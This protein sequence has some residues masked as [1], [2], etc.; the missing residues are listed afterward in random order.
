MEK[1]N[2]ATS[3]PP[4]VHAWR[5]IWSA[6]VYLASW[7]STAATGL[8]FGA[9]SLYYLL[10]LKG[11]EQTAVDTLVQAPAMIAGLFVV[12]AAL[13]AG[14]WFAI[15]RRHLVL[16][17]I[18]GVPGL[19]ALGLYLLLSPWMLFLTDSGD[20][21]D[22]GGVFFTVLLLS[23]LWTVALGIAGFVGMLAMA[24][25]AGRPRSGS[26]ARATPAAV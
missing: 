7:V 25:Q 23:W 11:I 24:V 15:L 21:A 14:S 18:A 10:T 16:G 9:I 12:V 3:Q 4:S 19:A 8:V 13:L 22:H 26:M 1:V 2:V 6:W 5:R 20:V 17:L